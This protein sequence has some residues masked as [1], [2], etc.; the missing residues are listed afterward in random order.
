MKSIALSAKS[1]VLILFLLSVALILVF[2]RDNDTPILLWIAGRED[3]TFEY[4]AS[5]WSKK[6]YNI[7]MDDMWHSEGIGATGQN[8]YF[9]PKPATGYRYSERFNPQSDYFQAWFGVYTIEDADNTTYALSDNGIDPQAIFVLAI[10]DQ[11]GW[12]KSFG[13]QQP[14]VTLDTSVPVDVS[15][16]QIDGNLGWKITGRFN[17]NMDVGVDNPRWGLPS[18]LKAPATV[19]HGLVDSY[20]AVSLD[21]VFYVWYASENKELNVIYYNGVEFDDLNASHHSTLPLISGELDAMAS[22][23]TVRK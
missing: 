9:F 4:V 11:K 18:L 22:G 8:Y 1:I 20:G 3:P 12:L 7:R 14:L 17:T 6:P 2:G 16:I 23:I 21:V 10:A 5:D 19:W 15:E 13:L